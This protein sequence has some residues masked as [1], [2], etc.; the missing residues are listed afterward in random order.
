MG[1]IFFSKCSVCS[2]L[3]DDNISKFNENLSEIYKVRVKQILTLINFFCESNV[4]F[5][6]IINIYLNN[7]YSNN[8]LNNNDENNTT[9]II[10]SINDA[11]HINNKK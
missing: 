6:K 11:D 8:T 5:Q 9:P 3:K 4:Y 7:N 1:N 2:I 10:N